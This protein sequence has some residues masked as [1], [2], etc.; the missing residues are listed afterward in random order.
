[1]SI[2]LSLSRRI[3][4]YYFCHSQVIVSQPSTLTVSVNNL[5]YLARLE[6]AV[7][8]PQLS[9]CQT[10]S[11]SLLVAWTYSF[12]SLSYTSTGTFCI[13]LSTSSNNLSITRCQSFSAFAKRS[14]NFLSMNSFTLGFLNSWHPLTSATVCFAL[15]TSLYALVAF[16]SFRNSSTNSSCF[17]LSHC[18]A[19]VVVI[20]NT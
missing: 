9:N 13:H 2:C 18:F 8:A 10:H 12:D 15:Y 6:R 16:I 14:L 11:Q 1:M 3:W 7:F 19:L 5:K 17:G 4:D 20:A